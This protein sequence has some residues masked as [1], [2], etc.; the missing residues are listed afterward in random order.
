MPDSITGLRAILVFAAFVIYLRRSRDTAKFRESESAMPVRKS[1]FALPVVWIALLV[2]L[3][4][5]ARPASAQ[6]SVLTRH[7]DAG[8]TGQNLRE[9]RLT[10]SNVRPELFG[11][12]FSREVDGDFTRNRFMFQTSSCAAKR[13][14]SFIWRPRITLSMLS[15]QTIPLPLP[16][17][18]R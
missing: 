8:R 15:T 1:L 18:G 4:A 9:A 7:N 16:R 5:F 2:L 13:A 11:K 14:M 17:S 3:A 10:T 12:L 6:I